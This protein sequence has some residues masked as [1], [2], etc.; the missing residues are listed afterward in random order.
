M[1]DKEFCDKLKELARQYGWSG[2][3]SEVVDFVIWV[4]QQS[5][6]PIERKD[7]EVLP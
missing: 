6:I 7:L 5:N 4:H 2:D 1:N 3:Y